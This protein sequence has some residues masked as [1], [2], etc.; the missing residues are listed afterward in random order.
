MANGRERERRQRM[1]GGGG[2]TG[3]AA[4]RGCTTIHYDKFDN[5]QVNVQVRPQGDQCRVAVLT[6]VRRGTRP[7]AGFDRGRGE[8]AK[9]GVA[10]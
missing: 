1:T 8:G 5:V 7:D 4:T 2:E 9:A 10:I 3:D 6:A